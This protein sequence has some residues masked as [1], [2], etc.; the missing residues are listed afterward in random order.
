[1]SGATASLF[2]KVLLIRDCKAANMLGVTV[3]LEIDQ[4]FKIYHT[5]CRED[6]ERRSF[7]S[8]APN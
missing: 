7:D 4:A 6:Q 2:T 1:M 8:K 5:Q 3:Q